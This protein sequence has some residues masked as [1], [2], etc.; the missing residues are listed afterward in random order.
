M[1]R[2]VDEYIE[3]QRASQRE[4]CSKLRKIIL[5]AYPDIIEK[6]KWGVPTYLSKENDGLRAKYYI[7][8]LKDK[9]NLGFSIEGLSDEEM[10]HFQGQGKEMRHIGIRSVGEIDEESIV[11]LL[12]LIE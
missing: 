12:G 7:V 3:R 9:V 10:A 8:A 11:R 6:M 5:G 4:I 1:D 2:R